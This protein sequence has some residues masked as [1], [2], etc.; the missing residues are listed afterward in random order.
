MLDLT[1]L[2]E[3]IRRF[4]PLVQFW[5]G[6][7]RGEKFITAMRRWTGR[8]KRVGAHMSAALNFQK[9]TALEMVVALHEQG[10]MPKTREPVPFQFGSKFRYRPYGKM[11]EVKKSFSE[12]KP[13][14][15]EP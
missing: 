10:G 15:A 3:F 2:V 5:D 8:G 6:G 13:F 9:T 12:R 4:G 11:D 1:T 14:S 7:W